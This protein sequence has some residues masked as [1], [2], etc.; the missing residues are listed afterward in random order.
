MKLKNIIER[1]RGIATESN[2]YESTETNIILKRNE[3]GTYMEVTS[4]EDN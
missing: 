3:D 4:H 1:L 2:D